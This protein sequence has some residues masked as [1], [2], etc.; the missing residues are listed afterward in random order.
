MI[1]MGTPV[2]KEWPNPLAVKITPHK[3]PAK[4]HKGFLGGHIALIVQTTQ[5]VVG[6]KEKTSAQHQL[7]RQM[8]FW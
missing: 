1:L 5:G 7:G 2:N 6:E 8:G 4:S 3:G